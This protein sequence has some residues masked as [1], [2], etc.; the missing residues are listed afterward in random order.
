MMVAPAVVIAG[1]VATKDARLAQYETQTGD[2]MLYV[3]HV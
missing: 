3:S 2:L 1:A